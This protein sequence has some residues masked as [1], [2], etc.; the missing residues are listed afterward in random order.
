MPEHLTHYL[1]QLNDNTGGH[2]LLEEHPDELLLTFYSAQVSGGISSETYIIESLPAVEMV[3]TGVEVNVHLAPVVVIV[4]GL[5]NVDL[6]AT[7]NI[8]NI[9]EALKTD[10]NI[11]TDLNMQQ[12]LDQ[13]AQHLDAVTG[14][15]F[16][17]LAGP[18]IDENPCVSWYRQHADALF[19][20]I[21]A[22][23]EDGVGTMGAVNRINAKNKHIDIA[24]MSF[25]AGLNRAFAPVGTKRGR[26]HTKEPLLCDAGKKYHNNGQKG[27]FKKKTAV[28]ASGQAPK[29][30][31]SMTTTV[32][33]VL[34]HD[35][36]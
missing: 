4:H 9:D 5:F 34:A 19:C 11:T 33:G 16:V 35:C 2:H 23:N 30:A 21:D 32:S 6:D 27:D 17:D 24:D 20:R 14:Q 25:T 31:T 18:A 28:S 7:K 8:D 15:N 36:I 22:E 12:I 26:S 13:G 10:F 3:F 29:A 1:R